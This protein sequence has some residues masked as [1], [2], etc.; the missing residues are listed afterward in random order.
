MTYAHE[1]N[2]GFTLIELM[3]AIA[4]FAVLLGFAIPAFR[5]T[6]QNNRLVAQNNEFVTALNFARSEA[7]RRAGPV[8]VCASDNGTDCSGDT[9][10]STGWIVFAD[11]NAD[12]DL[13]AP[14][15]ALQ[16][17]PATSNGL[18]LNATVSPFIRYNSTGMSA[19]A[20]T[21]SLLKPGCTGDKAR[22]VSVALTGRISTTIVACP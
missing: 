9:D 10:W 2:R 13:A 14:E 4:I 1:R 7:L 17:W 19:F 12:G 5:D 6:V 22:R 18:T 16:I 21:F 20:E 11:L 3:F 15:V 8:T